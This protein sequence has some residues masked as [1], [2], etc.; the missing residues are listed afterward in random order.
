MKN[1]KELRDKLR[2][3]DPEAAKL[4]DFACMY[5]KRLRELHEKYQ[6]DTGNK[7]SFIPEFVC[8]MYNNAY[9]LVVRPELN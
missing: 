3:K 2:K 4:T 9:D 8:Y 5:E 7:V 1:H 6:Q